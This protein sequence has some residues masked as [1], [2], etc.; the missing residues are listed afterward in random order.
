MLEP[1]VEANPLYRGQRREYYRVD[2]MTNRDGTIGQ[3]DGVSEI[4]LSYDGDP[5]GVLTSTG[6]LS[7]D[8]LGQDIDWLNARCQPWV[9]INGEAWPLG[10]YIMSAPTE[11]HESTGRSWSVA[12]TDKL[13]ILDEDLMAETYALDTG[14]N[15]VDAIRQ[16]IA[17]AGEANHAISADPRVLSGPLTWP[18]ATS[19][20][21]IVQELLKMLNFAPLWVDGWGQYVGEPFVDPQDR[22]V[23]AYF[24]EGVNSIHLPSFQV[25]KA[26]ADI[27][28][29]L[30]GV[31]SS[32]SAGLMIIADNED[33]T[34]PYS[35]A[36][37][38][39]VIARQEDFEA[40]DLTALAALVVRRMQELMAPGSTVKFQHAIVPLRPSSVVRFTSDGVDLDGVVMS[41]SVSLA[42]GEM[43]QTE[44]QEVVR[45]TLTVS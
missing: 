4:S 44:V 42:A 2:L 33:P 1:P 13:S 8:D 17:D 34:N 41:T 3:L 38:N 39:R 16:L 29:R 19:R 30:I 23:E 35:I 28:N 14:A 21:A 24:E 12:L 27:P 11:Q 45:V 40:A 31:S 6:S 37:R 22:P 9:D 15:I 43:M 36:A 18:A 7:L 20:L 10:V 26:I 25:T 5:D 32:S